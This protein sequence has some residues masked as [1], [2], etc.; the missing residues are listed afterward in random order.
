MKFLLSYPT[1]HHP[2][3][4]HL[5]SGHTLSRIA[6]AAESAGFAAIGFTDHPAP[7]HKW[8]Q[9]AGGHDAF[10]PFVALAYVAGVTE[11]L[12]LIPAILVLPYRNPLLVAKAA[13]SLDA[14]SHGRFILAVGAGYQRSEFNALGIDFHER[15]ALFDEAIEAIHGIWTRDNF[16]FAGRHFLARGQTANPKPT[17]LPI[18]I[19][20]NS[21]IARQRVADAGGGWMPFLVTANSAKTAR[22][23]QLEHLDD[24]IPMIDDLQRRVD[25]AG[26]DANTVDVVFWPSSRSVLVAESREGVDSHLEELGAMA[27]AGVTWCRV[28]VP[29][30]TIDKAVEAIHLYGH[31]VVATAT[32]C[33]PSAR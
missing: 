8:L 21:H 4:A 23:S 1:I 15:N 11:R 30:D 14:L 18:W 2:E 28:S 12:R 7:S 3:S 24:L 33:G 10:D 19:G 26:R 32:P 17:T 25:Q 20:G 5:T 31:E 29:A 22:S 13:A 27:R 9:S 16:S 6:R